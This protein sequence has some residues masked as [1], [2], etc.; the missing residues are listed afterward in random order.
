MGYPPPHARM[1]QIKRNA[2]IRQIEED[3]SAKT[4]PPP[5]SVDEALE[6]MAEMSE[7]D[8]EALEEAVEEAETDPEMSIIEVIEEPEAEEPEIA[9]PK[10]E[11]VVIEEEPEVEEP[12][13]EEEPEVKH[14][15]MEMKRSELNALAEEAGVKDPDKLP[16]KKAV[17][18]AITEAVADSMG[19]A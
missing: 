11:A 7:E 8:I 9:E 14:A 12:E 10:P 18:D 16:N 13:V 17:I 5:A 1:N 15:G 2:V 6:V 3:E 19:D 4:T